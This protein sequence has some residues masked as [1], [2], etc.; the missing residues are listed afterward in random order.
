MTSLASLFRRGSPRCPVVVCAM[1]GLGL[2]LAAAGVAAQGY[3]T[4]PVRFVVPYAPGGVAD[5]TA[6]LIAQKMGEALGQPLVIENRPSA[7]LILASE[8]VAKSEPDGHT[9]LLSG[10][11]SAL[12]VSMFKSLPFDVMNDFIHVSRMGTFDLA[13]LVNGD[14]KLGSVAD[15]LG[16]ARANPGKLNIGTISIGSTQH[17]A[18]ELFKS[19]AGVDVQT[20]PFKASAAVV[21]ALRSGDVQV[22]VE[23]LAPVIAQIRSGALKALAVTSA[24][25]FAG[26]P[27]V[28]TVAESG[29]PRL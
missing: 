9:L 17:L 25:R 15:L 5:I 8:M 19:M 14:S 16:F 11:G 13:L 2:Q 1:L 20:V 12:S 21:T 29:T 3:P 22:G 23:I 27:N 26:L 6:R 7:G 18:A 28:P 24:Q 4:K 10:N